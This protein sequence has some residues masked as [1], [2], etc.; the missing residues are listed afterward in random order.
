MSQPTEHLIEIMED[1]MNEVSNHDKSP[2]ER[3]IIKSYPPVGNEG[4]TATS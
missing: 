3:D 4:G 1:T 2:G